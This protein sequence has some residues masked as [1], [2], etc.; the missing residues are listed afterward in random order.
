MNGLVYPY[1]EN[2]TTQLRRQ[3]WLSQ[4]AGGR[5]SLLSGAHGL[6]KSATA[7]EALKDDLVIWLDLAG[8]SPALAIEEFKR[9][10]AKALG[11]FVP[12]SASTLADLFDFLMGE[13][14]ERP[15]SLVLDN[16]QVVEKLESGFSA[17]LYSKWRAEKDRTKMN[18]V[19]V[20]TSVEYAGKADAVFEV[21]PLE[22]GLLKELQKCVD[23]NVTAEDVLA[24][25][26]FTGG[27]PDLVRCTLEHGAVT[28]DTLIRLML[29]PYSPLASAIRQELL[30]LLGK[31][32]DTYLSI[33]SL[34]ASGV[35]S[36][37]EMESRLGGSIIGG[38]LAKL[39]NEYGL[40]VK[41]RP[42]LAA[43]DSRG[44][45][46][47]EIVDPSVA[48]WLRFF[49]EDRASSLLYSQEQLIPMAEA[50]LERTKEEGLRAYYIRKFTE[51]GTFGQIG[52]IWE[53]AQRIHRNEGSRK[54]LQEEPGVTDHRD[55]DIVGIKGKKALVA[56]VEPS[57]STFEKE[58]FFKQ[59]NL[60]KNGPLKGYTV[61][62]RLFTTADI[63]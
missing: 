60:L 8:K 20:G 9:H 6:G 58:P 15:F 1:R 29:Q 5:L 17:H 23:Q 46:R 59:V 55:A 22:T 45:V 48:T 27:R 44:V 61:D 12:R 30:S 42:L 13:A 37:A 47:Y 16:F 63:L 32:S 36:Q 28:K 4:T 34:I 39:E 25:W 2:C 35:K 54:S 56:A 57:A 53:P 41:N 18:I 19:L 24:F 33:L 43:S 11:I 52:S 49:Y 7:A 38:H 31:N 21:K 51:E 14:W 3:L 62:V 40:L 26:L 50:V 10:I